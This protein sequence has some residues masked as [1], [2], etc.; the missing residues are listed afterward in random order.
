MPTRQGGSR[1]PSSQGH[2]PP[3][4]DTSV[5]SQQARRKS[6]PSPTPKGL[7]NPHRHPDVRGTAGQARD[8]RRGAP[9]GAVLRPPGLGGPVSGETNPRSGRRGPRGRAS[10]QVMCRRD[11]RQG[12]RGGGGY[13]GLLPGGICWP[14]RR[15]QRTRDNTEQEK[16][17]QGRDAQTDV[18]RQRRR[19]DGGHH[20]SERCLGGWPRL[21]PPCL[22][23]NR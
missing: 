2:G 5:W 7:L 4:R 18:R 17:R 22:P 12:G 10:G 15:A 16:G 1:H 20:A 19:P 14:W 11:G 23:R 21:G 8:H 3:A 9:R 6:D 13:P